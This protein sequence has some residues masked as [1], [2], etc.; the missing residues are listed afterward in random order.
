MVVIG[1]AAHPIAKLQINTTN[2][3]TPTL[4]T[5]LQKKW[6]RIH[7]ETGPAQGAHYRLQCTR[8]RPQQRA[9]ADG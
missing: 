3:R 6:A 1:G 9:V 7:Q 2:R 5:S 8:D 4:I